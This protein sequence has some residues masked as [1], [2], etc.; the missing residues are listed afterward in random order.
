MALKMDPIRL[1]IADDVGIGKTVESLLV[2][3]EMLDRG[4]IRRFAVL[5]PPHLAEQWQAELKDKFH[6]D[7]ELVL[8]NTARRLDRICGNHSV[9][10][11]F[12]YTVVSLDYIKSDSHRQDFLARC[13]ELVIVDE[14]HTCTN[15]RS[16][17]EARPTGSNAT[18]SSSPSLASKGNIWSW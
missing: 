2:A 10:D 14:A 7:A 16:Q 13:P 1:L 12:D 6:I 8:S 11:V 18:S 3:R 9:F 5:C 17:A 4:E 15:L